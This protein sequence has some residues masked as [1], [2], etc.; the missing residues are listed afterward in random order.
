MTGSAAMVHLAVA[1][2]RAAMA[3]IA[4]DDSLTINRC[5]ARVADV[6][7]TTARMTMP[8]ARLAGG[9]S[10]SGKTGGEGKEGDEFFHWGGG[11]FLIDRRSLAACT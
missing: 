5:A 2:D 8:I 11:L 1:I 9:R 4:R 3:I 10:E 7:V 6:G